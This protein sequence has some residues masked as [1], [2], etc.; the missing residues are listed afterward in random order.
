MSAPAKKESL[1]KG[2]PG[3]SAAVVLAA[4]ATVGAWSSRAVG[5]EPTQAELI[6]QI[7]ALRAKVE[8]LEANQSAATQRLDSRAVDATVNSV[9]RDAESRSQL[10]QAQGFT[11]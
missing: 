10:L 6:Q 4:A 2:F 9:L 3:K 11:A 7:E 1:V 5:A 8:A